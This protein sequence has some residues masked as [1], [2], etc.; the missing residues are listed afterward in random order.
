[1]EIYIKRKI[2]F[3]YKLRLLLV[4]TANF[5][6]MLYICIQPLCWLFNIK[7]LLN[8]IPISLFIACIEIYDIMTNFIRSICKHSN[9]CGKII[10]SSPI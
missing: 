6:A 4:L 1:M 10:K 8:E 2:D 7:I 3:I 9:V 5:V